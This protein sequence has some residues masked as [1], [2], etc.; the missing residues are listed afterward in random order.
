MKK[1]EKPELWLVIG[2]RPPVNVQLPH[3]LKIVEDVLVMQ[4]QILL[5]K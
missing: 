5:P 1:Q 3:V 2:T 4:P